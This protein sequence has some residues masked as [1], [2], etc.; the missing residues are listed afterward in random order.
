MKTTRFIP[1]EHILR[2]KSSA[3]TGFIVLTAMNEFKESKR[4]YTPLLGTAPSL[5]LAR[6]L[7]AFI[8]WTPMFPPAYRPIHHELFSS[9]MRL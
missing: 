7:K 8:K 6:F 3:V 5:K 9:I 4:L 1:S 2:E